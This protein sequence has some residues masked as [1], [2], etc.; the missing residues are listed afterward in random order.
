[1][2]S[3]VS[4]IVSVRVLKV[5]VRKWLILSF[6]LQKQL[7][8]FTP[9]YYGHIIL[10]YIAV[11]VLVSGLQ[12]MIDICHNFASKKNLKCGTDENQEKSKTKCIV[13]SKNS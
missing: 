5:H 11:N 13:L 8:E 4:L 9:E 1:M 10:H 7:K 6:D 12:E 3:W 2:R